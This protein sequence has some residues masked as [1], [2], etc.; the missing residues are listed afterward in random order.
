MTASRTTLTVRPALVLVL[1]HTYTPRGAAEAAAWEGGAGETCQASVAR[2][3]SKERWLR[4]CSRGMAAAA[5]LGIH[6]RY[7]HS[8]TLSVC[9]AVE[10][11]GT[12]S[13]RSAVH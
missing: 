6:E 2:G 10:R 11:Q 8:A 9:G 7:G 5:V 4:W 1:P 13:D 3:V 12:A